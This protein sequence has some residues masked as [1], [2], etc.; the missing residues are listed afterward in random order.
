MKLSKANMS[1]N[2]NHKERRSL[3]RKHK[4]MPY[5]YDIGCLT[6][7]STIIIF[8]ILA[9]MNTPSAHIQKN[10]LPVA[11]DNKV[12]YVVGTEEPTTSNI[13]TSTVTTAITHI[14]KNLSTTTA[15]TSASCQTTNTTVVEVTTT[16]T[17]SA[18]VT[19]AIE[20]STTEEYLVYKPDTHYVHR[21]TC[22][23]A[24]TGDVERIENT[25]GIE[26][27][28]CPDC[29]PDV[30]IVNEYKEPSDEQVTVNN[31]SLTYLKSFSRGTFY[32][33]IAY[34]SDPTN[35]IGGSGRT[36]L[37]ETGN[38]MSEI[39]GSL[40]SN[41][42]YRNYGY[43]RNNGRTLVYIKCDA[44]EKMNGLYYLDD[45]QDYNNEVIDFFYYYPES[46]PFQ[47]AGVITVD[48]WLVD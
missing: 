26:A 6:M 11:V 12:Q 22:K 33:G 41:Y 23:W 39:K 14:S 36:L 46:C 31:Y 8:S 28:K 47:Q 18:S 9:L 7:L 16:S 4:R 35:I 27:R 38:T 15:I 32:P 29:N 48:A 1:K 13:S 37:D 3:I 24:A 21:S 30:D 20:S 45:S 5:I 43:N 10:A 17:T 19:E 34:S 25:D 44:Y 2:N 42:I 40:A